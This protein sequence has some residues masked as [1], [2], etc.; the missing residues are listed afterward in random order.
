MPNLILSQ[1]ATVVGSVRDIYNEGIPGAI[2]FIQE[3]N[4][5]ILTNDHGYYEIKIPAN[6]KLLIKFSY[7]S[8]SKEINLRALENGETFR[9]NVVL[10]SN[11]T[12]ETIEVTA[13]RDNLKDPMKKVD[14]RALDVM[15]AT[16]DKVTALVKTLPGFSSNN[17]LSSSYSVRGGNFD[18][19]VVYINDVEIFRPF[20]VRAGQQEGLSIINSDLVNEIKF[21]A[22]GFESIYGDKMSSVLDIKYKN[23]KEFNGSFSANLL[24]FNGHIEGVTKD[25]SFTYMIGV[26]QHSNTYLLNSMDVQGDYKS[27]FTDVQSYLTYHFNKKTSLSLFSYFGNNL[28]KIIPQT[29]ETTYG[30]MNL[31]LRMKVYFDG[32]EITTY[33]NFLNAVDFT[34]QPQDSTLFKLIISAYTSNEKENYDVMGQYWLGQVDTDPGSDD[35]GKAKYNIGVGT[36]LN[37]ARNQLDA[38]II[39]IEHKG[40]KTYKKN[41]LKWGLKVQYEDITDKLKEWQMIDSSDYSIP[42]NDTTLELYNHISTK[43]S[44]NSFRYSA[45]FQNTFTLSDSNSIYLT[46]GVRASYWDYNQEFFATPR[47]QFSILPNKKHNLFVIKNHLPDSLLKRNVSFKAAAGMYYQPAFYREL[48]NQQGILNPEIRAQKSYQV[49]LGSELMINIWSRP[50]KW[51]TEIYYK[52]LTDII[53]YDVEDVRIRYYAKN[54]A[55]GYSAGIDMMLY[56]EFIRNLPSWVSMSVMSTKENVEDDGKGNIPRPTDQRFRVAVFFQ[57][58]LPNNP[59][60]K[61]HLNFVYGTRLPFG[62]PQYPNLRNQFR[63]KAYRRV[64]IGFS[65]L[66]YSADMNHKNRLKLLNSLKSVWMSGEI[67]NMFGVDNTI[68]YFWVKDV[69]NNLWGVPNYLTGRRFNLSLIMKF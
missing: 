14:P 39:N 53:P 51:S 11:V 25:K 59:T 9:L 13:H 62:P 52:Y 7:F 40:V 35:F 32:Q 27:S 45:Y 1:T 29:Q 15:P 20:L 24:G 17:E 28:Y 49:V 16:T 42:V 61:V 22:G 68:S 19:N 4:T 38:T 33:K 5:K 37:H 60:S 12:K 48:R 23:P 41:E 21:S 54:N 47:I 50:F 31:V 57:D 69:N 58:L 10:N 56:G 65:K 34:Y 18:E 63:M 66:I 3:L 67:F 30:T 2:V 55:I 26:R 36:F 6:K 46:T 43:I 44:L 64:D 8:N